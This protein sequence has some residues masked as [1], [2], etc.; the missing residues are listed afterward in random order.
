MRGI[1]NIFFEYSDLVEP[2]S[3]DE[4]FLDITQNNKSIPSATWIAE[5]IRKEIFEA[6][7][8]T[9]SAGVSCNK[10]LAKVASDINK[11]NGLT[12][13]V[14]TGY[15]GWFRA[16]GDGSGLG[17]HHYQKGRTFGPGNCTIDLWPDLREAGKDERFKTECVQCPPD[18]LEPGRFCE[19]VFTLG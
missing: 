9:A 13:R 7:G 3:L 1:R 14:V 19:W 17:F 8:L 15:Q 18:N 11:P 16:E 2:L 5:T 6:T 12:G 4:A 10:F